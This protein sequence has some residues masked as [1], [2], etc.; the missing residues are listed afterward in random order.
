MHRDFAFLF[1]SFKALLAVTVHRHSLASC[2]RYCFDCS[3]LWDD[4][5][6]AKQQVFAFWH[7]RLRHK[8]AASSASEYSLVKQ[9][10]VQRERK[11]QKMQTPTTARCPQ[12]N[13]CLLKPQLVSFLLHLEMAPRLID[14]RQSITA[15]DR[16]ALAMRDSS[17]NTW[18]SRA[19]AVFGNVSANFAGSGGDAAAF[20]EQVRNESSIQARRGCCVPF[21]Q[22]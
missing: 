6:I 8:H 12:K 13:Q 21:A 15:N 2:C 19:N 3:V 18:T 14:R 20:E 16:V 5:S 1:A 22:A 11:W 4:G 10:L 9:T 7:P 17:A